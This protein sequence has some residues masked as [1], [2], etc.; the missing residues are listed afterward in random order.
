MTH[1]LSLLTLLLTVVLV[2]FLAP[3]TAGVTANGAKAPMLELQ[4]VQELRRH[5]LVKPD[6][7][8][9]SMDE[10]G[11]TLDFK[12]N[13]PDGR[14]LLEI[15]NPEPADVTA[16]DASGRDLSAIEKNFMDKLEYVS[17][18]HVYGEDPTGFTFHL[19][20][21]ARES[22]TFNLHVDLAAVTFGSTEE[23][24]QEV[25]EAWTTLDKKLFGDQKVKVRLQHKGD[26]WSL[27]FQPGTIK[28]ALDKVQLFAGSSEFDQGWSMWN[29]AS[30]S[31]SFSGEASGPFTARLSVRTGVST[32]T[33]TIDLNDEP[34]P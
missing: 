26:E 19:T 30:L 21:P 29:D 4:R 22:K 14:R 31:Y 8:S 34:L 10:P 3:H 12:L 28:S 23:I 25:G 13:L 20:N 15:A 5:D 17:I 32:E 33:L 27:E 18:T 11:L 6:E 1:R 9:F 2:A 7:N 16:T 24:S